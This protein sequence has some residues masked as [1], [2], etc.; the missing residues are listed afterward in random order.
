LP[1]VAPRSGPLLPHPHISPNSPPAQAT[2]APAPLAALADP[3]ITASSPTS[4]LAFEPNVG[5]FPSTTRF[6]VQALG[7]AIAF[8][9]NS[10]TFTLPAQAPAPIGV[11]VAPHFGQP[12]GRN[13]FE[14]RIAAQP[15][16]PDLPPAVFQQQFLEVTATALTG[17]DQL[18]GTVGYFQGEDPAGWL[19]DSSTYG[20]IHYDTL[21]PG[22][23]LA[24]RG[25][26]RRVKSLFTVAPG[27]APARIRWRYSGVSA[28]QIDP[29]SGDLLVTVPP[30]APGGVATTLRETAPIAW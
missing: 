11:G 5:Q 6:Q 26:D 3:S 20:S 16:Q 7:G 23:A 4:I 14:R 22:I 21:Y 8:A 29:I 12:P 28:V 2:V 17:S 18:P 30:T 1:Y 10:L 27:A 13:P 9:P 25:Q 19:T 15:V 24:Y